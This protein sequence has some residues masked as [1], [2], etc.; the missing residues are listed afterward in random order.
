[1]T[2]LIAILITFLLIG[3]FPIWPHSVSWGYYPS[4]GVGILLTIAVIY[5]ILKRA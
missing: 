1:M 2:L 5:F 4:G 3:V